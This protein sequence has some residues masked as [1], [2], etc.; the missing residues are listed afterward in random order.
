LPGLEPRVPRRK[1]PEAEDTGK[2]Q[3]AKE[4]DVRKR[5]AP[6]AENDAGDKGLSAKGAVASKPLP[7]P[8]KTA[9][10][11]KANG[12]GD[13]PNVPGP[14]APTPSGKPIAKPAK[15]PEPPTTEV[16][17]KD[18][19]NK[20]PV[21]A[22]VSAPSTNTVERPRKRQR[23]EPVLDSDDEAGI[24]ETDANPDTGLKAKSNKNNVGFEDGSTETQMAKL[25]TPAPDSTTQETTQ[26][27]AQRT[28]QETTQGTAQEPARNPA[29]NSPL[30]S[31]PNPPSNSPSNSPSNPCRCIPPNPCR[32]D[33][34]NPPPNLPRNLPVNL[35]INLPPNPPPNTIPNVSLNITHIPP[36]TPAGLIQNAKEYVPRNRKEWEESHFIYLADN[37]APTMTA[38]QYLAI[39]RDTRDETPP[40]CDWQDMHIDWALELVRREFRAEMSDIVIRDIAT[41]EAL[42]MIG[43]QAVQG[44]A[45]DE[46][47]EHGQGNEE[48]EVEVPQEE[49]PQEEVP[50]EELPQ[51]EGSQH[52]G[53][54]HEESQGEKP[55]GETLQDEQP[56]DKEP[57][58]GA[59]QGKGS[60]MNG[61]QGSTPK[62][63]TP[64]ENAPEEN[65]PEQ[66]VPE[67][68]VPEENA[69]ESPE[70]QRSHSPDPD[71]S[72]FPYVTNPRVLE[73]REEHVVRGAAQTDGAPTGTS[74][75]GEDSFLPTRR[76]E[77]GNNRAGSVPVKPR[78]DR[79]EEPVGQLSQ[80]HVTSGNSRH[81]DVPSEQLLPSEAERESHY[82][83]K[84][85]TSEELLALIKERQLGIKLPRTKAQSA[86]A[87][88]KD[89]VARAQPQVVRQAERGGSM[90]VGRRPTRDQR[91]EPLAQI[92][93]TLAPIEETHPQIAERLRRLGAAPAKIP[94][95]GDDLDV[96][97][98]G[99]KRKRL[100]WDKAASPN[101]IQVR[102]ERAP[103]QTANTPQ[104]AN[105]FQIKTAPV[106]TEITHPQPDGATARTDNT[107]PQPDETATH[108]D[109]AT[110]QI[111]NVTSETNGAP[112]QDHAAPV[113]QRQQQGNNHPPKDT[114]LLSTISQQATT[115]GNK[116]MLGDSINDFRE[117]KIIILPV[118][119]G[120][121]R[122]RD[123]SVG[124]GSHWSLVALDMRNDKARTAGYIDPMII[125][126]RGR[127]KTWR[128][129]GVIGTNARVA[130]TMLCGLDA[131]LNLPKGTFDA[132]TLKWIPNQYGDNAN[133]DDKGP[134]GPYMFAFLR[135]IMQRR[136][137]LP[138]NQSYLQHGLSQSFQQRHFEVH[139]SELGFDS[140][141][142]RR[143]MRD[144]MWN[145]RK[146]LEAKFE[147]AAPFN[148]TP[149]VM[150]EVMTAEKLEA[151]MSVQKSTESGNRRP[152][153]GSNRRRPGG[154]DS[155][156]D[157]DDGDDPAAST[158]Q[159][160]VKKSVAAADNDPQQVKLRREL[161]AV[162]KDQE[163]WKWNNENLDHDFLIPFM[164]E[165]GPEI[166]KVYP[167]ATEEQVRLLA[168]H[169]YFKH[170]LPSDKVETSANRAAQK[171]R[172]WKTEDF[173]RD[174]MD[175]EIFAR[176]WRRHKR[177]VKGDVPLE[178]TFYDDWLKELQTTHPLLFN[179]IIPT[180]YEAIRRR[181]CYM[182]LLYH[183][184]GKD[185]EFARDDQQRLKERTEGGEIAKEEEMHE[186]ENEMRRER[187][188][189]EQPFELRLWGD[190]YLEE[191]E[192]EREASLQQN[193]DELTAD[194]T[195]DM[196]K[197]NKNFK[198]TR[199]NGNNEEGTSTQGNNTETT[200]LPDGIPGVP[201]GKVLAMTNFA[202]IDAEDLNLWWEENKKVN[203]KLASLPEGV[204]D[205]TRRAIL[206]AYFCKRFED[207]LDYDTHNVWGLDPAVFTQEEIEGTALTNEEVKERM[208][209]HYHP[210]TNSNEDNLDEI[211]ISSGSS[212]SVGESD[213][214]GS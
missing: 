66:K 56:Q 104:K 151:L 121:G 4:K 19:G 61:P 17:G 110:T 130:A 157:G 140:M 145:E 77:A 122:P 76:A 133:T 208:T 168:A 195:H 29:L 144:T 112:V 191:R 187:G 142:L 52:E 153:Q 177:G 134:C 7:K 183:T 78:E 176:W 182:A 212:S 36:N 159:L 79:F 171:Y 94:D 185:E 38:Q 189:E 107:H 27:T 80:A 39:T 28:A 12:A 141:R 23:T 21:P 149:A 67:E 92:D 97:P 199:D 192:A 193:L 32:C 214:S 138:S 100:L 181:Y 123:P 148:L 206:S 125:M 83:S 211:V 30:D 178:Q 10:K 24:T 75:D 161:A 154:D 96:T 86:L 155:N 166:K 71:D 136:A 127:R 111:S 58:H 108:T 9:P 35:P 165:K 194:K 2:G 213:H 25:T 53:S 180:D 160:V 98:R 174:P 44:I 210:R 143:R 59:S 84:A 147:M 196:F 43:S 64:E 85:Y 179:D 91:G 51:E 198:A 18:T 87:L 124:Q 42:F 37:N 113:P 105:A 114:E 175:N 41:S 69:P 152:T 203:K 167:D 190:G 150:R 197:L 162:N 120:F 73:L 200:A 173:R 118:N 115:G 46:G 172:H 54:Q 129:T 126:E 47:G 60:E 158:K 163:F 8:Q 90:P 116:N 119:D 170:H 188:E 103:G 70:L 95:K 14:A 72:D 106:Q 88:A 135:Y 186:R 184:K 13:K 89:D 6:D 74:P 93:E 146:K 11:T 102:T 202:R 137:K 3:K 128:I 15:G 169:Y 164:I 57:G 49:V 63:S 33:F 81:D 62:K 117:K 82:N 109:T 132:R 156:D 65:A 34:P 68:N 50:Q 20:D 45:G 5:P 99:K 207:A 40:E 205:I 48:P 204:S 101:K 209:R 1:A 26:G 31:A 139:K 22:S 201:P 16:V 131:H 55:Q